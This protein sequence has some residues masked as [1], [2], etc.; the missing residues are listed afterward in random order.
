VKD[1][2]HDP[3]YLRKQKIYWQSERGK[4]IKR[5]YKRTAKGKIA[6]KK[7]DSTPKKRAY[8]LSYSQR[9]EVKEKNKAYYLTPERQKRLK[10][11]R[12]SPEVLE[13]LRIDSRRRRQTPEYKEWRSKYNKT[14]KMREYHQIQTEKRRARKKGAVGEHTLQEWKELKIKY[15]YTCLW[16]KKSEP[17]IKLTEDH[18][19][20]LVMGGTNNIDNIQPLCSS[21]NSRKNVFIKDF[22]VD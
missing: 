11:Y 5:K 10:E 6:I 16:C 22:R 17:E 19:I 18:V 14:P 7:Y 1:Y 13:R 3:E 12:E 20:P 21:C 15:N 4:E 9:P 2:K 8:L